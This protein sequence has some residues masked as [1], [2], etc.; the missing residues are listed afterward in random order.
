[1]DYAL[2]WVIAG[3]GLVIAE[4]VTGTF[5]LLVLGI[6]AFAGAAVSYAGG[7]LGIQAAAAALV[8]IAGLAWVQR[9]RRRI[10]P[11][12]MRSLDIGHSA[13]FDSWIDKTNGHARVKYRD[14]LWDAEVTGE[15]AGEPGEILYITSIH[16]NTLTVSKIRPA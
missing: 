9:Y 8:A 16:G 14:A 12:R 1:M 13:S 4:L 6:A 15:A 2:A 3:F 7:G 10:T 11:S 5:Y